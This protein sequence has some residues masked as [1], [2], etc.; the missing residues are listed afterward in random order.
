V[1]PQRATNCQLA[2]A[3][4]HDPAAAAIDW[5]VE[6]FR[7]PTVRNTTHVPSPCPQS[8]SYLDALQH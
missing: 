7:V 5:R 8:G 2:V 3:I 6:T 1:T 4:E